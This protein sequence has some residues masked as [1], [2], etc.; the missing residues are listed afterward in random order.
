VAL[1]SGS[2][3]HRPV[4]VDEQVGELRR[5]EDGCPLKEDDAPVAAAEQNAGCRSRG[6]GGGCT[7]GSHPSEKRWGGM[8]SGSSRTGLNTK[9]WTKQL[10]RK[11][12]RRSKK[13]RRGALRW[14]VRKRRR[15]NHGSAT[16]RR[17]R[18]Q[19]REARG[20]EEGCGGTRRRISPRRSSSSSGEAPRLWRRP[21]VW[22]LMLAKL[23]R[24]SKELGIRDQCGVS[25]SHK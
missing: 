13:P 16:R 12:R 1:L 4:D 9:S 20:S 19:T 22:T 6:G 11:F 2:A 14:W 10:V 23:A 18:L 3:E 24:E 5:V 21:A 15:N 25:C 7:A 17:Q 8:R